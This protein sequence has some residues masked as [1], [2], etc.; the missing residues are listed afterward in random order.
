MHWHQ[1][2]D[3]A[4]SHLLYNSGAFK[5]VYNHYV[6]DNCKFP[7]QILRRGGP[8]RQG[9]LLGGER[10]PARAS[11]SQRHWQDDTPAHPDRPGGTVRR[12]D[13]ARQAFAHWLSVTGGGLRA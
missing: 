9:H 1:S 5:T 12:D 4:S 13:Y 8:V 11:W 6:T 3:T 10:R 7:L 2:N